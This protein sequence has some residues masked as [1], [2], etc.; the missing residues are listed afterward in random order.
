[1]RRSTTHVDL[2]EK[3]ACV[4]RRHARPAEAVFNRCCERL[5]P[6]ESV[7]TRAASVLDIAIAVRRRGVLPVKD[8]FASAGGTA[9]FQSGRNAPVGRA[10]PSPFGRWPSARWRP[11][12]GVCGQ[13]DSGRQRADRYRRSAFHD[14]AAGES[15]ETAPAIELNTLAPTAARGPKG[16]HDNPTGQ[17]TCNCARDGF[18]LG[19]R[20]RRTLHATPSPLSGLGARKRVARRRFQR[21]Q[22]CAPGAR[23]PSHCPRADRRALTAQRPAR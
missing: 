21:W 8:I 16:A 5:P 17:H 22:R 1:M 15:M 3:P 7:E 4:P 11:L 18:E 19:P 20:G 2:P 6:A 13:R 10:L 14:L 23:R 12:A 9:A